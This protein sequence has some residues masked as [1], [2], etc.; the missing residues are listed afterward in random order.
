MNME[1][2]KPVGDSVPKVNN[3][4]AVGDDLKFQQRWWRFERVVWIFFLLIVIAD[5]LGCFGRGYFANAN[6]QTAD[7][8]TTIHYQRIERFSTPSILSL[9]FGPGNV[10]DGKIRLWVSDTLLKQLGNQRVIPQ[11]LSSELESS[12]ITY[13]FASSAQAGL[14]EFALE[15]ATFGIFP[16]TLRVNDAAATTLKIYVMP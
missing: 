13:T 1:Q 4:L 5:L 15:P 16:L 12:G 8:M 2:T 9:Q 11:P 6:T 3:E 10:H 7:G 14:I